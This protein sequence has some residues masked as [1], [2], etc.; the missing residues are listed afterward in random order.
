MTM[1]MNYAA[2]KEEVGAFADE[3]KKA[4]GEIME[5]FFFALAGLNTFLDKFYQDALGYPA[6]GREVRVGMNY[7]FGGKN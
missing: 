2:G 1:G 5:L 3:F 7:R 6:L 4:G